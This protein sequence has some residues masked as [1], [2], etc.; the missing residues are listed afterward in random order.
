MSTITCPVCGQPV[1]S[2]APVCPNCQTPIANNII[3]CPQCGT[4]YLKNLSACPSC[5]AKN[6]VAT[7]AAGNGMGGQNLP[8]QPPV[9][10][11]SKRWVWIACLIAAIVIGCGAY[12]YH[13]NEQN[14]AEQTAYE[15]ALTSDDPDVLQSYLDT[16]GEEN[17]EHRAKI[18]QMLN[19]LKVT[20][21]EWNTTLV[22]N[23]KQGFL[24]FLSRHPDTP[25]K[26]IIRH[27]V[28]SIDWATAVSENTI[29]AFQE[30]LDNHADGEHYDEAE[31]NIKNIKTT[32]V[33]PEEED[34]VR[35]VIHDFFSSIN[36]NSES[37][38]SRCVADVLT[39]FLGKPNATQGDVID[40]MKHLWSKEGQQSL[41]W[42]VK[43]DYQIK[44]REV[45]E[46]KYDYTVTF[47]AVLERK[48]TGDKEP[49]RNNYNI[50]AHVNADG[51]VSSMEMKT[52]K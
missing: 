34:N 39:S 33:Q 51:L 52:M 11:K 42:Y 18:E 10:K 17:P 7:A 24:D 26:D 14:N 13:V 31:D 19:K 46:D 3:T 1:D 21:D 32:V 40:F 35:S 5:H 41:T 50:T 4:V 43:D 30:Y 49:D 16:Y 20:M 44:K 25:Y 28:D 38:I 23:S 15:Q 29:D 36:T 2:Q 12:F 6:P 47:S 8:P 45:G 9:G 27:K 22:N 48:Y 37:A